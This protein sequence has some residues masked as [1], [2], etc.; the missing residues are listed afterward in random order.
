MDGKIFGQL[1][2]KLRLAK[3]G[4]RRDTPLIVAIHGGTYTSAYFDTPGY[5][6][7]D[8]AEALEIPII[9]PDRPGYGSSPLS[10]AGDGSIDGQARYLIDS[11]AD[12]WQRYGRGTCGIFL[13]GHSIGGAIAATIA[14]TGA[15]LPI[16]G[17]AVSGVG[18]RTP[19]GHGSQWERLPDTPIVELPTPLKDQLMFGPPGAY[20]DSM[21]AASHAANTGAPKAELV[22]ITNGWHKRVQRILGN[23]TA[24]V[25][26]RQAENDA[27]WIVDEGEV[28][29][30]ARACS[31]SRLVDAAMMKATGHCMDFHRIGRALQV[32]QLG[33]ALQCAAQAT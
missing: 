24:P 3:A 17:L 6:L 15:K 14:S 1:S 30:F 31:Q 9:A 5:S 2:G 23:I 20:D 12:A 18:M 28:S 33:F 11:L 21:P 29:A 8:R 4:L 7:M 19:E 16:I 27:L 32:Q 10:L 25:H 13:I 22:D 26:Y